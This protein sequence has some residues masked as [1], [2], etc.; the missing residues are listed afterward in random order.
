MQPP[1]KY[2]TA[3]ARKN[4]KR[5]WKRRE[6]RGIVFGIMDPAAIKPVFAVE[7]YIDA[8]NVFP[9]RGFTRE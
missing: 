5:P 1:V 7:L 9:S 4:A 8:Q 2:V 3:E 6:W